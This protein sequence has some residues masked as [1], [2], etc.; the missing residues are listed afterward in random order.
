M[1]QI[2]GCALVLLTLGLVGCGGGG[3][4]S[5]PKA[6]VVGRVLNVET[7]GPPNPQA[8]IQS[9]ASSVLTSISDG[10]FQL[11]VNQGTA[12]LTVD[13]RTVAFGVWTFTIP[14]A[15][16]VTDVGDLW[17]GPER[18]TLRGIVRN[19]ATEAPVAGAGVTFGGRSGVTNANGEFN[20]TEVAYS[21]STQ[22]AFWGIT[23]G[24]TATG[25]FRTEFSAQP[26][27]AS[28]G[29]VDVGVISLTATSDPNP[30][31][32]PFN[33]WGTVSA[34]G[35]P[36][37]AVVRL[38]LGGTEVRVFNVGSDGR[39]QFFIAPGTYTIRASKGSS[40]APDI[41]VT[42]SQPNA[43]ERRNVAIP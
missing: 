18:V 30:P 12:S 29:V 16:G 40:T 11:S 3:G 2:F 15:T 33:L 14:S 25:F 42:L 24:V 38:F 17:V 21:S 35:G 43:V 10:S 22:T 19:A 39:Y 32:P 34:P 6:T 36:S 9:G 28:G 7:G 37:G 4:G 20:L 8:S 31:G 1:R 26:N 27:V 41:S 23:G 5:Q 13:T